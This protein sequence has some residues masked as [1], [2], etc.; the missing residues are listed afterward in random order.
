MCIN[1]TPCFHAREVASVIGVL[2]LQ[3]I[4]Q[5]RAWAYALMLFYYRGDFM[6]DKQ[7]FRGSHNPVNAFKSFSHDVKF[8]RDNPFY[9]EP[10]GIW[11]YCGSQGSGKSLSATKTL[12]SLCKEYP[13]ALVCSNM[14]I[15]GLDRDIIPFTQYE[16]LSEITNGIY[17]VIYLIDEIHV[18]WNSL[19]SKN[20][21]I[22]EMAIFAQMRKDRRVI[23][24]TSQVYSRIAK[25][26][27]EQLKY[28]IKCR[29]VC[30]YLQINQ[31]IDPNADGYTGEKDGEL[32]GELIQTSW[33]FHSPSDYNSYD[34]LNKISRIE[35]KQLK[36]G[37][38][39]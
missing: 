21:P 17:G 23:L 5:K 37:Y 10:S 6:S 30:K 15:S 9:F 33:F 36:R 3:G 29:N 22:S 11:V 28:V 18:L 25:P 8:Y 34:T 13:K 27:R 24:G 19:E 12:K 7:F 26:I 2:L 4:R 31:V 14:S 20:I 39:R 35:R 1:H 38:F 32:E 16:Q